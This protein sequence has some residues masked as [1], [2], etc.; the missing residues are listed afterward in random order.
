MGIWTDMMYLIAILVEVAVLFYLECK[1]WKSLYTPLNFLMLPYLAVLLITIM[2][3]G[4]EL[5]FVEFYYPSIFIW[6]VGLFIF[7][8]PSVIIGAIITYN[9]RSTVAGAPTDKLPPS[10]VFLLV[11]MALMFVVHLK[12]VLGNSAQAL[13][14]DEFGE[15]FSGGGVWGHL[16]ILSL[17]L[18]MMSIYYVS[19]KR[20]WLWPVI[21]VFLV[22]G[23]L[24]QVK[25]WVII[26][27]LAAMAM[28]ICAGKTRLSVKFLMY[29]LLGA[30]LV[31]F[32]SYALSILLVQS[33]GVSDEFMHF[34]YMHFLHYLTSGTFG[35]SMDLQLGLPDNTENFQNII[36]QFVNLFKV[37]VGD[38]EL[39]YPI[40]PLYF[41]PGWSL[42]NVRTIFGTL[43]IN[44]NWLSFGIYIF[45]L[46][47]IMYLMRT[48]LVR[49]NNIYLYTVYF[50]FCGMLFMGWF[51][52][53]FS[54]VIVFEL[55]IMV[56]LLLLL[57]KVLYKRHKNIENENSNYTD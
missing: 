7:F 24:N 45:V 51:D 41:N 29:V 9:G 26:P 23:V 33:R 22:V 12:G 52:F 54:G 11:V 47:S 21:L 53:Y 1:I 43:Y 32:L 31:F 42:T 13:G 36:A 34:I 55:P 14:S 19:R 38:K 37:F 20:W 5:G 30:F 25:G 17:P 35:W 57:E 28:R 48:A 40:N 3:S 18:L 6:N 15:E 50:F 56:L 4:G 10:L 44:S 8:L 16:R 27:V 39:V 49:F 2:L 46:S